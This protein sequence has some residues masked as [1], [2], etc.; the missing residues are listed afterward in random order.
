MWRAD[1]RQDATRS[2]KGE[3]TTYHSEWVGTNKL[4]SSEV[5]G[6][7]GRRLE[8]GTQDLATVDHGVLADGA[9]SALS[10]WRSE[11][12]RRQTLSIS[13]TVV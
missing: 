8:L 3:A 2:P 6:R 10:R 11:L 4:L 12:V 5:P 13:L 9:G 7:I 1:Q